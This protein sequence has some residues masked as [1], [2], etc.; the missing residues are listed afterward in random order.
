MIVSAPVLPVALTPDT[1]LKVRLVGCARVTV[2]SLVA[3][4]RVAVPPP[5][6]STIVVPAPVTSAPAVA[7]VTS[8]RSRPGPATMLWLASPTMI[9]SLPE[10]AVIVR[11]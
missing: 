7:A 10:L 11:P 6:T 3:A 8:I 4:F 5:S 9:V 1:A 2:T